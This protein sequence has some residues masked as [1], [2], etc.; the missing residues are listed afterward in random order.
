MLSARSYEKE[1][2]DAPAIEVELLYQNLRELAII[3]KYLGGHAVSV[4]GIAQ[5]LIDP[6]KTYSV[7]DIGCGGGDSILAISN[8]AEANQRKITLAGVDLKEDCISY[9][10]ENCSKRSSIRLICDDFRNVFDRHNKIDVVHA[11]LFCHHFREEDIISFIKLCLQQQ[12]TFII[13]DLERHPVAY[14]SIRLLARVFSR[15]PLVKNDAP[16]SVKRGF[17]KSEWHDILKR[18]GA[19]NYSINNCWAFRHL[20][21]IYPND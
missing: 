9:A 2:L 10:T 7:M 20:I 5:V 21:I 18:A 4:R 19:T 14:Y 11:A 15:S 16:L 3:N 8:W 17:K 12:A 6:A 13:N 1:L